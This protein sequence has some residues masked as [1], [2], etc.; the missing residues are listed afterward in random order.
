MEVGHREA[1]FQSRIQR[2]PNLRSLPQQI[3]VKIDQTSTGNIATLKGTV[4]SE[5]E[6]KI[7]KQLLLLEPGIDKVDNQIIVVSNTTS[8]TR[9][10]MQS[11]PDVLPTA[12]QTPIMA[13]PRPNRNIAEETDAIDLIPIL[14]PEE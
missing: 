1:A 11:Q 10:S 12:Y 2:L 14:A 7:A 6:R 4:A 3:Q 5:R 8:T 13:P 9:R